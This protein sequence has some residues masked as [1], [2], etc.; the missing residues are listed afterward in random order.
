MHRFNRVFFG[1]LIIARPRNPG[2]QTKMAHPVHALRFLPISTFVVEAKRYL[3]IRDRKRTAKSGPSYF[4]IMAGLAGSSSLLYSN[5][6][7]STMTS[8]SSYVKTVR[9]LV[10]TAQTAHCLGWRRSTAVFVIED[11]HRHWPPNAINGDLPPANFFVFFNLVVV[12]R[13]EEMMATDVPW[14]FDSSNGVC[15]AQMESNRE[16][17]MSPGSF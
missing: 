6:F 10:V 3:M 17:F 13:R 4:S 11:I 8:S 2:R 12:L 5:F 9:V 16:C 15:A 7:R 14:K 1:D